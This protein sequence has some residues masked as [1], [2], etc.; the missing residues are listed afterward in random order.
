[1]RSDRCVLAFDTSAAHC[2]AALLFGDD[3]IIVKALEMQKGQ[4]EHLVPL[5]QEVIAQAGKTLADVDLIGVGIGPGNF[6]G[7]RIS[8]SLARSLSLSL[9]RPALGVDSFAASYFGHSGA[10]R[11]IVPGPQDKVY[12]KGYPANGD[13]PALVEQTSL[14]RTGSKIIERVGPR[15]LVTNIAKIATAAE[16]PNNTAPAPLYIKPPDAAPA[17]DSAPVLLT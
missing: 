16:G 14:G 6:T 5:I 10:A 11:V 7:I 13:L 17:R 2:A 9:D 4:A 3:L 15:F 12:L 1:M 8:V